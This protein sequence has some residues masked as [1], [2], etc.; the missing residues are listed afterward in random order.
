M[1]I[2][3]LLADPFLIFGGLGLVFGVIFLLL[4]IFWLWMLI[5]AI[6]STAIDGT[7]KIIWVLVILFTHILGAV[8]YFFVARGGRSRP[9][10]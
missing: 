3:Q 2:A 10:V 4:S 7:E 9:I 6:T 8:I 1:M 5:D